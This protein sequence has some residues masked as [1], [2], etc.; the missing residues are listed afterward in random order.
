MQTTAYYVALWRRSCSRRPCI[1]LALQQCFSLEAPNQIIDALVGAR[2]DFGPPGAA[3]G[4]AM[5]AESKF[6]GT[7][8][9]FGLQ[10]GGIPGRLDQR[11]SPSSSR[12][13]DH[14]WYSCQTL[15]GKK[16]SATFLASSGV[17]SPRY[18]VACR[19]GS[20]R[21]KDVTLV[22]LAIRM[23]AAAVVGSS[24]DATLSLRRWF[25]CRGLVSKRYDQSCG[26]GHR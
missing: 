5:L 12:S 17:R 4:I 10:G 20:I 7:F 2:A 15:Q 25:R 8:K 19:P 26:N 1:G 13:S 14:P 16:S 18:M 6:P 23:S 3:A 21:T 24:V 9:V 11:Q 22:D